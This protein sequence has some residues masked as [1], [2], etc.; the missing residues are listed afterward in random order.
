M[1]ISLLPMPPGLA[2]EELVLEWLRPPGR[3]RKITTAR[4]RGQEL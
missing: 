3:P 1:Y 4:M 2:L